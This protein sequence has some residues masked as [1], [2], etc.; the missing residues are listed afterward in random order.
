MHAEMKN[1]AGAIL[2]VFTSE[3]IQNHNTEIEKEKDFFFFLMLVEEEY[4]LWQEE[5]LG[6]PLTGSEK[7]HA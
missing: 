5:P 6:L 2:L 1:K 3:F 7:V 4:W